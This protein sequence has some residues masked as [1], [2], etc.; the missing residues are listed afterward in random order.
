MESDRVAVRHSLA[1]LDDA[2]DRHD[3]EAVLELCTQDVVFI[4]SGESEEAVGRDAIGPM[5]DALAPRLEGLTFSLEWES[6][7]IDLLGDSLSYPPADAQLVTHSRNDTIHYRLTGVLVR[8]ADGWRWH[9]H[10]GSEL[11]RRGTRRCSSAAQA[12]FPISMSVSLGGGV[13]W[14]SQTRVGGG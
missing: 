13:W 8:T 2:F 12:I 7:D 14:R 10:R 11:V 3:L 1:L 4:G 5:F 9:I 6:V